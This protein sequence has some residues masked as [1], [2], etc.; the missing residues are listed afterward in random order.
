[1]GFFSCIPFVS[2]NS[3]QLTEL[4]L[5]EN[6]SFYHLLKICHLLVIKEGE[7]SQEYSLKITSDENFIEA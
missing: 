7:E 1:M 2:R 5:D 6:N 4:D 3:Y